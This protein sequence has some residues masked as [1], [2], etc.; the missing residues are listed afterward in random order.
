MNGYEG[1]SRRDHHGTSHVAIIGFMGAGKSTVAE[2]LAQRSGVPLV[3]IDARIAEAAQMS[4]EDFF[5]HNGEQEFRW[6]E[7]EMLTD[8][9]RC[10][11]ASIIACGGGIVLDPRNRALLE[12][13]ATVIYL[14]VTAEELAQRIDD[15]ASRPLLQP[16]IEAD[17]LSDFMQEREPLYER[18]ADITV[19]TCGLTPHEVCDR[20]VG[21]LEEGDHGVL[22]P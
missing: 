3:D 6:M 7:H 1:A 10:P 5:A 16:A 17:A 8:A 15:Y 22:H 11:D 19:D 13:Q 4:I 20:I 18:V 9:L 21:M 2:L 12:A 14:Q